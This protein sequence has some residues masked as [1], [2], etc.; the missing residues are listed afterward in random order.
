[1][2]SNEELT[3]T[4]EE[5]TRRTFAADTFSQET[6]GAKIESMRPGYCRA[7]M[8]ADEHHLNACGVIHGGALFTLADF[9]S[10]VVANMDGQTALSV[11]V[12]IE[13]LKAGRK[14]TLIAESTETA[15]KGR[16]ILVDTAIRDSA[17][18]LLASI[19]ST[20][21]ILKSDNGISSHS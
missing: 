5:E 3:P 18:T 20:F 12:N 13:Y 10:A 4:L 6:I 9:A 14:G 21:C 1:M 2:Q 17:G 11:K 7:S 16:L 15:R 8:Q 19:K